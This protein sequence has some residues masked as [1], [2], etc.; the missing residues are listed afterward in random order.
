MKF[1][2]DRENFNGVIY[3]RITRKGKWVF[4]IILPQYRFIKF[5]Y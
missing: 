4:K 3:L 1:K 2:V 5:I